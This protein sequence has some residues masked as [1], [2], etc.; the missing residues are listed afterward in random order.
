[1]GDN[2]IKQIY[3]SRISFYD[4][5]NNEIMYMDK[6][7]G[8]LIWHFNDNNIKVTQ[9]N[10]LYPL[11]LKIMK[12]DYSFFNQDFPYYKDNT[13]L[14]WYSDQYYNPDDIFS[15]SN[16]CSLTI[17][18]YDEY[19]LLKCKRELD[20]MIGRN[21]TNYCVAFSPS[22]HGVNTLN[23]NNGL[24]FQDDIVLIIYQSLLKTRVKVKT[25]NNQ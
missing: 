17:E 3:E 12:Q 2:M 24:S 19:F 11:L 14:V 10:D 16:I 25:K 13:K 20:E 5:I 23:K 15:K 8:E 9:N 21:V 4:D 6:L 1:M 18:S 22:G 7:G